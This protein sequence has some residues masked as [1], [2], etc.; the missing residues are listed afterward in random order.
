ML[1]ELVPRRVTELPLSPARILDN[2]GC[3]FM[4]VG[5]IYQKRA[6]RIGAEIDAENQ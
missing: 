5:G 2:S 1:A 3:D 6:D 4:S